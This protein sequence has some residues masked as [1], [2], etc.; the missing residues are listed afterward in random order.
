MREK[1]LRKH[2]NCS[3]CKKPIG[4]TGVPLFFTVVITRHGIKLDAV[5]RQSG[6]AMMMGSATLAGIMGPDEEMTQIVT[7]PL[8]LTVCEACAAEREIWSLL[9]EEDE[10]EDD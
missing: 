4:H 8:T 9:P 10:T 7:G 3:L 2:A 1:E 6:M 5:R